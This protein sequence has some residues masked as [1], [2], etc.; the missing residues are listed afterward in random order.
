MFPV[1]K[2]SLWLQKQNVT[3]EFYKYLPFCQ[4][5]AQFPT[6]GRYFLA[7]FL[8]LQILNKKWKTF[9]TYWTKKRTFIKII[10]IFNWTFA[11][12]KFRPASFFWLQLRMQILKNSRLFQQINL[13][14]SQQF[15]SSVETLYEKDLPSFKWLW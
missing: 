11:K 8:I 6:R 5:M 7:F 4:N 9:N 1:I 15:I 14:T 3:F 2:C 13:R 10:V 12:I